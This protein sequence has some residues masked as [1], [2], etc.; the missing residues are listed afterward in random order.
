MIAGLFGPDAVPADFRRAMYNIR[1]QT[2]Q[3]DRFVKGLIRSGAYIDEIREIIASFAEAALRAK[4]AGFDGVELHGAHGYLIN[5]FLSRSSNKRQDIY[6]GDLPNRARFLIEVIKAVKRAV[7]DDYPVWC[8]I[9]GKECG[10]E[11][12]TTLEQ[13]MCYT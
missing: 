10:V 1:C 6:G 5:Q 9:N 12:R 11:D 13:G 8:R 2:G 4:K 3:R 7:G